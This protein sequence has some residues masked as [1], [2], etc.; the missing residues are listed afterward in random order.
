MRH[1]VGLVAWLLAA[2]AM[3]MTARAAA[4]PDF[5]AA[6]ARLAPHHAVYRLSFGGS[7]D[8][9]VLG[10][11]GSMDF[12]VLDACDAWATQQRLVLTI[13][14]NSGGTTHV[15]SDYTTYEAKN[16]SRFRFRLRETTDGETTSNIAGEAD[17]DDGRGVIRYTAPVRKTLV[18]PRGT[19]FPMAHTAH[20]LALA[21]T[22]EKFLSLPLFDGSTDTGTEDTFVVVTGRSGPRATRF[23]ALSALPSTRVDIAFFDHDSTEAEPDYSSAMRYWSNGVADDLTMNFG[24][25]VM[26]GALSRLTIGRL[27]C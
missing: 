20:I 26:D 23:A 2:L 1:S 15:V 7:P 11:S 21:A 3:P 14:G 19:L 10:G 4:R 25:F 9:S 22:G 12:R 27:G 8:A 18:L 13:L 17:I 5:A 16:G 6:I 24:D